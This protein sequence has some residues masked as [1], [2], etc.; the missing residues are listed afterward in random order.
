MKTTVNF[1]GNCPFFCSEYDDFSIHDSITTKCNLSAFLK[2]DEYFISD[3]DKQNPDWCPLKKEEFVFDFRNFSSE[4]LQEIDLIKIEADELE[5]YF[6]KNE[7]YHTD[8]K[9]SEFK[10]SEERLL[11]LY[12][13]LNELYSNEDVPLIDILNIDKIKDQ[14]SYLDEISI[15]LEETIKKLG[16]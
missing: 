6:D 15:K 8:F 10:K 4:R 12:N 11:Y 2:N 13:K 1:C 5:E 7:Y 3:T 16:S 9:D 14:I